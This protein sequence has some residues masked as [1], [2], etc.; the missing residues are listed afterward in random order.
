MNIAFIGSKEAGLIALKELYKA[1]P[2]H[3]KLI[4]C[5]NDMDDPRNV[6]PTFQQFSIDNKVPLSVIESPS[7]LNQMLIDYN[8][9][10]AIVV[11][12]YK[13]INIEIIPNSKFY[14][15]HY[16]LLPKYRGNAP[17]VWQ[18]LNGEENIGISLFEITAGMDEGD[19]IDQQSFKLNRDEGIDVALEKAQ[20]ASVVLLQKNLPKLSTQQENRVIQ[21]HSKATYCG[22][23]LPED[24]YINWN[25]SALCVHDFIRAQSPPYPGAFTYLGEKK[26]SILKASVDTRAIYAVP[27]SIFERT[28]DYVL[29]GCQDGALRIHKCSWD[30]DDTLRPNKIFKSLKYR[31]K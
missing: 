25:M 19:I 17:L 26:V 30:G 16:S 20:E 24:G 5:P 6:H 2:E 29:V 11:G 9:D 12:W 31:L 18:I 1:T 13:I 21:D 28:E 23:R 22:L 7:D 14:G 10:L 4:L 27:G 3:L 15:I 8:I